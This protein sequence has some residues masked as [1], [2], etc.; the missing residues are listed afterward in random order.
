MKLTNPKE[1]ALGISA[2]IND[3]NGWE[4][5]QGVSFSGE[6]DESYFYFSGK[7]INY[8]YIITSMIDANTPSAPSFINPSLTAPYKYLDLE[9]IEGHI[10]PTDN[11]NLKLIYIG[12]CFASLVIIFAGT[13]LRIKVVAIKIVTARVVVLT[14]LFFSKICFFPLINFFLP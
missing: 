6:D 9:I 5:T 14:S 3:K 2:V 13:L 4:I 12:F 8:A 1:Y 7:E 10:S 11:A